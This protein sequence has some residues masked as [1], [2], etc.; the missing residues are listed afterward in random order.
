MKTTLI[1]LLIIALQF[2]T[3]AFAGKLLRAGQNRRVWP[4]RY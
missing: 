1:I 2:A 3:G 4:E